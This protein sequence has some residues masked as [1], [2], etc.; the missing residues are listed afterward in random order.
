MPRALTRSKRNLHAGRL[1]DGLYLVVIVRQQLRTPIHS[2]DAYF[3]ANPPQGVDDARKLSAVQSERQLKDF[4]C[5]IPGSR[6]FLRI[7]PFPFGGS[8]TSLK[9]R[10]LPPWVA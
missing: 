4:S 8:V 6:D 9:Y 5:A 3:H 2:P 7:S 1:K 10:A